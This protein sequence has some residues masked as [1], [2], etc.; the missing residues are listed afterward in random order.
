ME[1][2]ESTDAHDKIKNEINYAR[3]VTALL[4]AVRAEVSSTEANR[5]ELRLNANF[6]LFE[7]DVEKRAS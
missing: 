4:M 5:A 6:S 7:S 1:D 3:A 2:Q